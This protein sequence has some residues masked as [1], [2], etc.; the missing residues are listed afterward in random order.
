MQRDNSEIPVVLVTSGNNISGLPNIIYNLTKFGKFNNFYIICPKSD[1]EKISIKTNINIKINIINEESIIPNLNL[2]YIYNVLKPSLVG[3]PQKQLAGWYYQQFLKMAFSISYAQYQYYLIWDA[4]TLLTRE[5]NFFENNQICITR[6]Q[7]YHEP[8]FKFISKLFPHYKLMKYSHISQ[9]LLV[10]S[11]HMSSLL[12]SMTHTSMP[13]WE[14]ILS[15]L[16]ESPPQQLSE[17]ELYANYVFNEFPEQYISVRRNWYRY[18]S[19]LY[20]LS[21]DNNLICNIKSNYDFI[22]FEK[23]DFGFFKK[24]ISNTI[25]YKNQLMRLFNF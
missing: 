6:G 9:H 4:D 2:D 1:I 7:E 5:I 22:A 18:G 16:D 19:S 14:K 10:K 24:I 23:W 25:H 15:L 3:Y 20:N 11:L 21:I 13:W 12:E 8:Y 17:Y